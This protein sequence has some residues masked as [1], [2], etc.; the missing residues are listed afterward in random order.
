V[1]TLQQI[2]SQ[3]RVL[4]SETD[5]ANSHFSNSE[6]NSFTNQAINFLTTL[7]EYP[8]D[9]VEIQVEDGVGIY[10]LLSDTLI[11]RTAYF[12]D[13]NVKDDIKPLKVLTEETLKE[14]FPTWL[15][16]TTDTRGRPRY[17]I[18]LNRKQIFIYPRPDTAESAS[19]KKVILGYIFRPTD[20]S[21]DGDTP[22]LPTPYHTL[23]QFYAAHM[24][25]AGK[26]QRIDISNNMFTIFTTKVQALKPTMIKEAQELLRFQ[27]GETDNLE[28]GIASSAADLKVS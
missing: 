16:E 9:I 15:D 3:T 8:R 5:E 7:I 14:L 21:A 6:L 17:L 22:D 2:R 10:S 28:T 18:L 24:C 27:W 26:L 20:L 13:V 25:Y 4:I 12:G 23:L 11:I 19:G 1:S